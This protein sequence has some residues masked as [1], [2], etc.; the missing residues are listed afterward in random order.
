M[1]AG[2]MDIFKGAAGTKGTWSAEEF[3]RMVKAI[4]SSAQTTVDIVPNWD[5]L[6]AMLRGQE[7]AAER[8]KEDTYLAGQSRSKIYFTHHDFWLTV[9]TNNNC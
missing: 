5:D 2:F 1:N 3:H 6:E 7:T 9:L 8:A 4:E